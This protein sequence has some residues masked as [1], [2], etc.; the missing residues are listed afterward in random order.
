MPSHVGLLGGTFDPIHHGHLICARAAAEQAGLD[1]LILLPSGDPPHKSAQVM[2][3]V[4]ARIEMLHLAV[5]DDPLFE[6]SRFDADR[7]GPTYT[8]DTIRHFAEVLGQ[9]VALAWLIGADSLAELHTW[10]RMDELVHACQVLTLVRSGWD[11]IDWSE[12]TSHVGEDGVDSLKRGLLY[13]PAIEVSSSL[14][15]HRVHEQRSIRYLVPSAVAAFIE[16]TGLYAAPESSRD[17]SGAGGR[18]RKH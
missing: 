16:Q 4:E 3:D 15:R 11:T 18:I 14:V 6:I 9:D 13:T 1:R 5:K 8:V 7:P 17:L 12:L 2:T 10:H